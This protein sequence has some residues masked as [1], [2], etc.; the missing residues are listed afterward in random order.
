MYKIALPPITCPFPQAISPYA[1]EA[2]AHSAQWVNQFGLITTRSLLEEYDRSRFH[3]F[4]ARI[5]NLA[6][7]YGLCLA[8]DYCIWL[9]CVDDLLE[10]H[11]GDKALHATMIKGTIDILTLGEI[12][13]AEYQNKFMASLADIW[14]RV[15]AL[16]PGDRWF[17]RFCQHMEELMQA[18]Q[19][20]FDN[21][22]RQQKPSVAD[23][24]HM[25]P[26]L[27]AMH[28]C[29]DLIEITQQACLPDEVRNH[30]IVQQLVSACTL[31]TCWV[32][33]LVS[34]SR[35]LAINE[36]HNLVILIQHEQ[37]VSL[38]EAIAQVIHLYNEEIKHFL[39]LEQQLP[40]FDKETND[41]LQRFVLGLRS[42]VR[43]N[44]D[45]CI[46]D[47][48]RYDLAGSVFSV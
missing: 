28:P 42:W 34:Y 25:R 35:E 16:H 11:A 12:P 22:V 23:Y 37:Q 6:D 33:D 14:I 20:E 26:L 8:S 41:K 43:G 38:D 39:S 3:L 2:G 1:Q 31:A 7:Y 19:W 29:I 4:A 30:V 47:T 45:W 18:T 5:Y 24:L 10:H 32:N 21:R 48:A 46:Y 17:R 40:A 9:F 36:P 13:A 27:S 44:L 15:K